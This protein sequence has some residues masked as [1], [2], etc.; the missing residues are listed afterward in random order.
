MHERPDDDSFMPLSLTL[1]CLLRL[2]PQQIALPPSALSLS[3]LD[4][5]PSDALE[6]RLAGVVEPD[7]GAMELLRALVMHVKVTRALLRVCHAHLAGTIDGETAVER[8]MA[9]TIDLLPPQENDEPLPAMKH[10]SLVDQEEEEDDGDGFGSCTSE[11]EASAVV[12][13]R[14]PRRRRSEAQRKTKR[15]SVPK[16]SREK[17]KFTPMSRPKQPA[18]PVQDAAGIMRRAVAR[19]TGDGDIVVET[20]DRFGDDVRVQS[21]GLRALKSI[22]RR[23]RRPASDSENEDDGPPEEDDDDDDVSSD[24]A[25][26]QQEHDKSDALGRQHALVRL[27]IE[28]MQQHADVASLQR[29]GLFSLSEFASQATDNVALL[30]SLGGTE[31]LMQAVALLPDDEDAQ[32]AALSILAHPSVGRADA[33]VGVPPESH[34]LVLSAMRRFP[35]NERLQGLGALAL[36]NLSLRL[37]TSGMHFIPSLLKHRS[38]HSGKQTT[39]ESMREIVAKGG[40]EQVLEAM[41]RFRDTAL[42]QAAGCWL[43]AIIS[44]ADGTWCC[45]CWDAAVVWLTRALLMTR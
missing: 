6:S 1:T 38:T 34:R 25:S 30:S 41:K 24:G 32:L 44:Q 31:V 40:V 8:I 12:A 37:G 33:V 16:R 9:V 27:V 18:L 43:L 7:S 2:L 15:S 3:Q 20:M 42:V 19:D 26:S 21:H 11:P 29:D 17:P 23:F 22:I 36:S 28:R 39:E 14:R 10:E 5:L 13:E 4:Q 35:L 45:C